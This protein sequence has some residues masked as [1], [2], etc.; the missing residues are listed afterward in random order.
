M[1]L[2]DWF[3]NL[4]AG[5]PGDEAASDAAP[6][7]GLAQPAQAAGAAEEE[8]TVAGL[9]FKTAIDA[10]MKW[11]VRLEACMENDNQEGLLVDVVSRDDQCPLGKWIQ[12]VGSQR[13]GHLREFQEM[14]MEHARFHLCAGDVLACCIAG[15]KEGAGQKLRSG[16]YSRASARV[17]LHLARLYVQVAEKH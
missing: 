14:K 4:A 7:G 6:E 9:N 15:D 5:T 8:G 12:G 16:D 3:K 17:K 10:H 1:G 13:F 11:K 2:M